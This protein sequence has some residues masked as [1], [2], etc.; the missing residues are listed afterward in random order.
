M[1][2]WNYF[3]EISNIP[4]LMVIFCILIGI[5]YSCEKWIKMILRFL[6][7]VSLLPIYIAFIILFAFGIKKIRSKN[8]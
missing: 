6:F 1:T 3:A 2:F 4:V 7:K 8:L 5:F